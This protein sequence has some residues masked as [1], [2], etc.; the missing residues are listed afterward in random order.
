MDR[1]NA[2]ENFLKLM[3]II[4]NLNYSVIEDILNLKSLPTTGPEEV[5]KET[6]NYK[7]MLMLNSLYKNEVKNFYDSFLNPNSE[8]MQAIKSFLISNKIS[9][10]QITDL[11][12]KIEKI[13]DTKIEQLNKDETSDIDNN[14][15]NEDIINE[16]DESIYVFRKLIEIKT[17]IKTINLNFEYKTKF[18]EVNKIKMIANNIKENGIN[19]VSLNYFNIGLRKYRATL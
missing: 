9:D 17:E 5:S 6:H 13:Y 18:L 16:I 14:L 2:V 15:S 7:K 4:D 8:T 3:I 10:P 1:K 12:F 11:L 19:T